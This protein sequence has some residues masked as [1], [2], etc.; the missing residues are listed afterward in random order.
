MRLPGSLNY[1][2]FVNNELVALSISRIL[3][4]IEKQYNFATLVRVCCSI[5]LRLQIYSHIF[6]VV[7]NSLI[8]LIIDLNRL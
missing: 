6:P 2:L 4:R 8:S 7:Q 1:S 5:S 3:Q